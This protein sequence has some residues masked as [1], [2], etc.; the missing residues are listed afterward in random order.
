MCAW[1]RLADAG[2]HASL[3]ESD[4]AV[5][6]S[7]GLWLLADRRRLLSTYAWCGL[8][9]AAFFDVLC[10]AGA[11]VPSPAQSRDPTDVRERV[12]TQK[13]SMVVVHVR[14]LLGQ[15]GFRV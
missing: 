12:D 10:V 9:R 14:R 2:A 3:L 6:G 1:R 7:C 15:L 11:G 4:A 5:V 13:C 8:Y